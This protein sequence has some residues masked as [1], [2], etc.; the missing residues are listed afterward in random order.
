MENY[1]SY[2][3]SGPY[4]DSA[5]AILTRLQNRNRSFKQQHM[6]KQYKRQ[7]AQIQREKDRIER[8]RNKI[9]AML[10]SSGGRYYENNDGTF[11]DTKT[12]LMWC[13]LDSRAALNKCLDYRSTQK[14]VKSLKIGG[15]RDWRLPYS[16]ELA[17]IY[18]SEPFFPNTGSRWYWTS[19]VFTK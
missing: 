18:K 16:N 9:K 5:K 1:I 11:T 13:L 7:Q 4:V 8:E 6:E 19:E 3:P 14:Y 12:G 2:N 17:G 10:K 15:Y